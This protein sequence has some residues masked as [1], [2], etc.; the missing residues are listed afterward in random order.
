VTLDLA[1]ASPSNETAFY[2]AGRVCAVY[3]RASAIPAEE[4]LVSDLRAMLSLYEALITGETRNDS[5]LVDTE[6]NAP[7]SLDYATRLRLHK[8]IERRAALAKK[9][10]QLN[11]R[12][13]QV[14]G[15]NFS[16]TYGSAG[17]GYI[18]AHHLKPIACLRGTKVAMD[19]ISE[20]TVP[21]ANCHRIVHRSGLLDDIE[22]FKREHFH[23]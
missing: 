15:T 19:P 8:R 5:A 3:Y 20:F 18:E 4:G 22:R 12:T 16:K 21:C 23:G 17:D 2:E 9:V 13:C 1:P 14:C 10:K 7:P 6:D 11:G